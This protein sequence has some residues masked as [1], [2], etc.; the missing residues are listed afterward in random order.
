VPNPGQI[1]CVDHNASLLESRCKMLELAGYPTT[2][3]SPKMSE[4]L[5]ISHKFDLVMISNASD[6][7]INLIAGF[8]DGAELSVVS[9]STSHS[10][11]LTQVADRL[12]RARTRQA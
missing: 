7:E 3:T 6:L 4:I 11:L 9:E 12:L 5:L 10:E 8:S 1:L 2:K